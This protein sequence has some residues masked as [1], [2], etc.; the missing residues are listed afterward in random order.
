MME[1]HTTMRRLV[2]VSND[3][4]GVDEDPFHGR[5]IGRIGTVSTVASGSIAIAMLRS[6]CR[7]FL[8]AATTV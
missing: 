8:N 1:T 5:T 3:S 2:N 6:E 7:N 4:V